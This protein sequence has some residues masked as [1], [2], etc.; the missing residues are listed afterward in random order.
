V[1]LCV[2][3]LVVVAVVVVVVVVVV[4]SNHNMKNFCSDHAKKKVEEKRQMF[5]GTM[6]D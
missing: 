3:L 2:L 1:G 6:R 4:K 5:R